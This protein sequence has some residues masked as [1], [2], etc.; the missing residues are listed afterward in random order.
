MTTCEN[1]RKIMPLTEKGIASF[2]RMGRKRLNAMIAEALE[3]VPLDDLAHVACLASFVAD[4]HPVAK[5]KA[6]LADPD[7]DSVT[8]L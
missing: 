4:E 3:K 8:G 6:G 2:R 1:L 7:A 5:G